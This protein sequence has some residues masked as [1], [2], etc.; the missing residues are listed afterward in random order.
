VEAFAGTSGETRGTAPTPAEEPS[1]P[2]AGAT[3]DEATPAA[4]TAGERAEVDADVPEASRE[5]PD[6]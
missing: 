3:P 6:G 1:E 4:E 2:T 5:P